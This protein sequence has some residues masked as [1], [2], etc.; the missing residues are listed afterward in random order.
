MET[1]TPH[2]QPKICFAPQ[3][4]VIFNWSLRDNIVFG[5]EINEIQLERAATAACLDRDLELLPQRWNTGTITV[6]L[7]L[8]KTVNISL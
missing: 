5:A 1:K 7:L 6:F 4:H 8:Y 3:D 2:H